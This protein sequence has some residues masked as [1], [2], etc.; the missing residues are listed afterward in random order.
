MV[1]KG[2]Y[3]QVALIQVSEILQFAQIVSWVKYRRSETQHVYSSSSE[4]QPP[5]LS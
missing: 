5:Q 4:R 1:N 3:P 2:N